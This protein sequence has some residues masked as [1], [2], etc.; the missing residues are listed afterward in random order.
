MSASMPSPFRPLTRLRRWLKK[1]PIAVLL[2][3]FAKKAL[4][5]ALKK[6]R[7]YIPRVIS[8]ATYPI[9]G[10]RAA[11]RGYY[12][13]T[14]DFLRHDDGL[15]IALEPQSG[16]SSDALQPEIFVA[17]IPKGRSLYDYGVVVSPDHRLLADVSWAIHDLP[18]RTVSQPLY[19]PAMYKLHLPPIQH[20]SGRVAIMN[21]LWPDNYY[22]WMFD[23][24][25]RFEFLHRSGLIP[26]R[27]VINTNTSFQKESLQTLSIPSFKILSP[28]K[29]AHIEA[30]ELIVPSLPGPVFGGQSPQLQACEYLRKTFLQ[31]ERTKKPHRALYITRSDAEERRVINE[32]EILEELFDNGFEVI[33]LSNLPLV[34]QVELFS[35][36]KIIVGSHGAG[37]TNVVFCQP[38]SVL[39]EF[40]PEWRKRDY[41]EKLARLVGMEYYSIQGT[42]GDNSNGHTSLHDHTVD[43][44]ALRK[45]LRGP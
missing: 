19:H 24:L 12:D 16:A 27:Y 30:D 10:H 9:L 29:D 1:I 33:S 35:E 39:I 22:H 5:E 45:L 32:V 4:K 14:R 36:A 3:R 11:L 2:W 40:R 42:E 8:H 41:F 26:D 13:K 31:T 23:I 28:T 34:Q 15:Y 20:I 18:V 7:Y 37:L 25:P 21:S 44:A 17:I 43:R 6:T 38:S